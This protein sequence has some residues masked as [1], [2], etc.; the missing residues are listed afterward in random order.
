MRVRR[1][2]NAIE[3]SDLNDLLERSKTVI[4]L[5][6]DA[7]ADEV[8]DVCQR[9]CFASI[10][11][12]TEY[13]KM[14]FGFMNLELFKKKSISILMML[15]KGR[16]AVLCERMSRRMVFTMSRALALTKSEH[17]HYC[18]PQSE[19]WCVKSIIKRMTF[20]VLDVLFC[21]Q[22]GTILEIFKSSFLRISSSTQS[23]ANKVSA[24]SDTCIPHTCIPHTCILRQ[25]IPIPQWRLIW[26][27]VLMSQQRRLGQTSSLSILNDDVLECIYRSS[28]LSLETFVRTT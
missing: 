10:L 16:A 25:Y 15:T 27:A 23:N 17:P 14:M 7:I 22:D 28:F 5:I 13:D 24:N 12:W 4:V 9:S 8:R 21:L 19:C 3:Y 6:M 11:E 1:L 20:A 18:R 26:I 2:A